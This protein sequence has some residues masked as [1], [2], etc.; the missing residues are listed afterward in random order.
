[1]GHGTYE[2]LTVVFVDGHRAAYIRPR[3]Y[4]CLTAILVGIRAGPGSS[5]AG[6]AGAT[7][8]VTGG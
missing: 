6:A 4:A 8:E 2:C 3:A 7:S 5:A 1:M